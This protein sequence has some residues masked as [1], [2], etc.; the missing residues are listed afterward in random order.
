MRSH[1][2]SDRICTVEFNGHTV[3]PQNKAVVTFMCQ[4]GAE[5]QTNQLNGD[6]VLKCAGF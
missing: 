6:F 2:E 1:A 3:N 4:E 5:E